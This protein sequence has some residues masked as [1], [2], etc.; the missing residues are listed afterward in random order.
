MSISWNKNYSPD[1]LI[2]KI[3]ASRSIDSKGKVKYSGFE[4]NEYEALLVSMLDFPENI[5]EVDSRH[6]TI[7]ALFS[8]GKKGEITSRKLLN[9]INKLASKFLNKPITRFA[10]STS[11][12]I[13][14][15]L[16]LPRVW[17]NRSLIIFDGLKKPEFDNASKELLN[18][19]KGMLFSDLPNDYHS[20]RVHVSARSFFEAADI[21]IDNLDFLRGIWNYYFNVRKYSRSSVGKP[22]PI[23]DLILGP[24]HTL[25]YPNGNLAADSRWWFEPSYLGQIEVKDISRET[26][27]LKKF[28]M[29]VQSLL[30]RIPYNEL[31]KSAFI[32]YSRA[33]DER[34]WYYAYLKLWSL[35]ELLTDTIN[36]RYDVTIRRGSYIF[37]DRE[38]YREVLNHL[39]EYRNRSVHIDAENSEIELFMYQLKRI[40]ESLIEFHLGFSGKFKSIAEVSSF[41]RLPN[42]KNSLEDKVRLLDYALK[43]RKYK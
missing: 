8:V 35:L 32:R 18:Y 13:N 29:K 7:K 3:E 43:Y 40:I 12:S 6:I 10:L 39:R 42:D 11:M 14:N 21:A 5:S 34:N 41:L 9:E 16:H 33:L 24:I 22:K 28:F 25:H 31:L 23:N 27:S 1:D 38:Y 37:D 17:I 15:N 30:S 36:D 19:A 26:K 2:T 4:F 20:L